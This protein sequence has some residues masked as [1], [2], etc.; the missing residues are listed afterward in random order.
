MRVHFSADEI[1]EIAEEIERN[2][3]RF[4]RHAAEGIESPQK[5]QLLLDLSVMEEKHEKVFTAMRADLSAQEREE[6]AFDPEDESSS[7]LKAWADGHVFNIRKDPVELLTGQESMEDILLI[8]IGLEKDSIVFYLGMKDITPQRLGRSR[9][10][11]II[12]EEM[13]HIASL[14]GELAI[15]RGE[16][17]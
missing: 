8:A 6:T 10:D 15:L 2:G 11:D 9:V 13:N 14:S 7:Y 12:K 5:R 3:A 4:Y 17:T 1:L 16:G